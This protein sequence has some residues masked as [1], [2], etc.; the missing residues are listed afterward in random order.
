MTKDLLKRLYTHIISRLNG[1]V[2]KEDGKGLSSNDYTNADKTK[3]DGIETEANK[4]VVDSSLSSTSTNPVQ[5]KIIKSA[6]DN[7][8]N[9]NHTHS[10][11]GSS[12]AGGAASAA[13]KLVNYNYNGTFYADSDTHYLKLGYWKTA[14]PATCTLLINS[15]FYHNVHGSSDIIQFRQNNQSSPSNIYCSVSRIAL[16]SSTRKFYYVK[17]EINQRIYLYVYVTDGNGYGTH[18]ISVIQNVDDVWVTEFAPNQTLENQNEIKIYNSGFGKVSTNGSNEFSANKVCDSIDFV[19]GNNVTLT[20]DKAN[21]KITIAA[22]DTVYTHPSYTS[23]SSGLYKITVNSTGH[24]SGATSVAK[25]DIT[26]LGIASNIKVSPDSTTANPTYQNGVEDPYLVLTNGSSV[27]SS[28]RINGDNDLTVSAG[29]SDG[30]SIGLDQRQ[31]LCTITIMD[32]D[33]RSSNGSSGNSCQYECR[34]TRL[35]N[36]VYITSMGEYTGTNTFNFGSSPVWLSGL[37][38]VPAYNVDVP[39]AASQS[40]SSTH[41]SEVWVHL[42]TSDN[43]FISCNSTT[44]PIYR[45]QFRY[46]AVNG[47]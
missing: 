24:V 37:P 28:I 25:S 16:D 21:K 43:H 29:T 8:S 12:S 27:L 11:A 35:L 7:K 6:L 32:N 36:M 46:Y 38:F 45:F 9:S 47:T 2:D 18:R 13:K 4:T 39:L 40:G 41:N 44:Q 5:N 10:Y 22:K 34:Y 26:G 20:P 17:D 31:Y 15:D 30:I 3:L 19:G 33:Y 42:S 14:T 23:R 1:K